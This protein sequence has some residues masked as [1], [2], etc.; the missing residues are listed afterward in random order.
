MEFLR[1]NGTEVSLGRRATGRG[2]K[3]YDG[4]AGF[5]RSGVVLPTKDETPDDKDE[6]MGVSG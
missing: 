1:K 5:V 3:S 2:T 4:L 6:Q